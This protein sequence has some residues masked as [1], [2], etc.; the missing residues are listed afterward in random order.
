MIF[1]LAPTRTTHSD[2]F[3]PFTSRHHNPSATVA[4]WLMHPDEE[5]FSLRKKQ[6][7]TE[8]KDKVTKDKEEAP[9]KRAKLTPAS[10]LFPISM[11]GFDIQTENEDEIVLSTDL[12]GVKQADLKVHFKDSA[13]HIEAERKKGST[14]QSFR[15]KLAVDEDAIEVS[16]LSA[17]LEDGILTISIPQKKSKSDEEGSNKETDEK[18]IVILSE[19]P[20]VQSYELNM[21]IDVPGIK[22]KDLKVVLS[23]DGT[24]L[25]VS[26]E[27]KRTS[28]SKL[29]EA[30]VLNKRKLD[31]SRLE[32]YLMD[33]VL[34][35]RAPAKPNIEKVVPVNGVVPAEKESESVETTN[36]TDTD[37]KKA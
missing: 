25:T 23:K 21:E 11:N 28:G 2:L 1:D 32:A 30:Y 19:E 7:S 31:T 17:T 10:Q 9:N 27:R 35:I 22:Q 29:T 8:E 6:E 26:G 4:Y 36:D 18:T 12:P 3:F 20:P 14:M 24:V 37:K 5:T 16:K 33:G 15:R 13:I 34:T